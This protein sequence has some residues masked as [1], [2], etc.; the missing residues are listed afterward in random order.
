MGFD[1]RT[2]WSPSFKKM[3][4]KLWPSTRCEKITR[5]DLSAYYI[6]EDA[7]DNNRISYAGT[8]REAWEK[9][10]YK[11]GGEKPW[12]NGNSWIEIYEKVLG[13]E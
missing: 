4:K 2:L 11:L 6:Y 12:D 1:D 8:A 10:Y 9:A 13:D 7:T 5:G 3:T